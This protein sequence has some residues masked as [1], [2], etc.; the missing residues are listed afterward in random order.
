MRLLLTIFALS[1]ALVVGLPNQSALAHARLEQASPAPDAVLALSPPE[2]RIWMT[3]EL[4]LNG[5]GIT[6]SDAAGL[7]VDSGDAHVDQTDP[8]RKQLVVTLPPLGAGTYTVTYT[9]VSAEDGDT[10]TDAFSFM[11]SP[12]A[13]AAANPCSVRAHLGV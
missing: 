8:D 6:V 3:Q 13:P 11:V 1:V 9:T 10:F 2:V 5:S 12:D 7:Q 4:M